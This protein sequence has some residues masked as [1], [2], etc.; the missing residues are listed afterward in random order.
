MGETMYQATDDQR[1][2][3]FELVTDALH[4]CLC[5]AIPIPQWTESYCRSTSLDS[6]IA[7]V[8][9]VSLFYR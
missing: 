4:Q 6:T 1:V 5:S 9:T 7:A 3:L 2:G 8:E